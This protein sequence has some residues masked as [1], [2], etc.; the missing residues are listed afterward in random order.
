VIVCG[1]QSEDDWRVGRDVTARGDFADADPAERSAFNRLFYRNRR[2]TW[3]GHWVS[4]FFCWWA[5]LGLPPESWVA[6]R[7]RDRISG[8]LRQDAVVI[9]TVAGEQ[10]VV[11]MFGTISDWVHNLEAANGDAVSRRLDSRAATECS[12]RKAGA[13]PPRIRARRLERPKT[14]S[15]TN[16]SA[17]DQ[18]CRDCIPVPR[19]SS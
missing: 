19:V 6:L 7:V 4:Q 12:A 8:R 13:N 11:S 10:Y 9:P 1:G 2:P 15:V 3:V 14:L 18:V 5:R 16:G 17:A